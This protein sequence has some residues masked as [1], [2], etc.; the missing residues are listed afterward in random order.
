VWTGAGQ[1]APEIGYFV[2]PRLRLG[3]Q[4]RIQLVTGATDYFLADADP[5]GTECGPEH[6][7][8]PAKAAVAALFKATWLLVEP[9]SAFQPYVAFSAGGGYIRHVKATV[10]SPPTCGPMHNGACKDTVAGGPVLFGP[11][12]GFQYK[13]SD[14][15]GLVAEL[16]TLL[17]V[18][19]F[20][21]NADLNI[22]LAFTL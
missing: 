21:A 10:D 22:G 12:I 14:G 4:G 9:T 8:S 20:T 11:T 17:G 6:V 16:Q 13:L 15:L 18:S 19:K 7:C 1:L 5:N 3:V 2:T